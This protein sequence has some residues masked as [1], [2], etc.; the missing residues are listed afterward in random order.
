MKK[1]IVITVGIMML[2]AIV[3]IIGNGHYFKKSNAPIV[4]Q[5][6]AIV[7]SEQLE[8]NKM[9][10]LNGEWFFY[11]NVL[12]S[13]QQLLNGYTNQPILLKVPDKWAGDFQLDEEGPIVGT[14]HLKVKVPVEDQY[15]L[16]FWGIH[17]S[18]RVFINGIEVGGKGNPDTSFAEFRSEND[19]KFMVIGQSE[20]QVLDIL[21]QVASFKEFPNSGIV[22]SVEFG[23]RDTIQHFYDRKRLTDILAIAGY[24][25]FGIIYLISY[26][27]NRKRKEELFFGLFMILMGFHAS[28]I[29]MKIFFQIVP[30]GLTTNQ[31]Q[32]QLGIIPL[33][34]ICMVLF[35]Y[36]MYPQ[37]TSKK[38][39]YTLV[40]FL[41]F[42]FFI[43]GIYN[44]FSSDI[45]EMTK[46]TQVIQ[47]ITYLL[48]IIPGIGYIA[49]IL[50]RIILRNLEGA[51]Y[52]LI[53]FMATCCYSILMIVYILTEIS[54]DYSGLV[55]FL[56]ILVGFSLLLNYR[57]NATFTKQEALTEELQIHNHMKDEFLLKTS[58]ELRTPLNGILNLSKLLM[59]G[60]EGSLKRNQQEQ[61]ILIHNITQRLGEIVEDLLFS[62]N[63]NIS[64]ELRV[65]PRV[66]PVSI[67]ND[68]V[69]EIRSVMSA[70]SYVRLLV[71]VD[72]TLSPMLTD[73]LRFK[74][75][76][77][78]LLHNALQHTELGE[79]IVTAY[80]RQQHM[81][82]EVSDTGKGIPVQDLEH[83]FT[84][85]Y[86]VKN[87]HYQEGLGLGLS[88]AKNIVD[89]LNGT[90]DVKSTLGEGTTFTFTMPL[91]TKS[92]IDSE[93]SPVTTEQM[94][95][96]ILQLELPLIH[97]GNDKKI[98][99]V[100]DEHFNI[101]VLTDAL[102]LKG[103]TVIGVDNGF[104]AID[105]IK[106]NQ[107]DCMLVDLMMEGMSGYELCKQVRKQYD[108]LEL[109]IIV[110]TAIMKHSD[111][112]LT[113]QLGANDYLQKPIAMD[114]LLLRIESLL[115][116]RQSSL[117]AI[118]VEMNNLYSQVTPHFVYN[119]LTTIIGLSYTDM[120]NAREALYCLTTYFRA[121][122]NV[123][124]RNNMILLE[125]EIELVKA[126]LAIE[127][128]RF[129][130]RLTIKYNID[131]SIQLMIPALSLQPLVENAVFHGISKK[132]EGGTIEVSVQ[133]EGQFVQIKIYDNGVGIPAKKLQQ[134][135]NEESP[136]IGF[137]NPLK[138]FKLMKNVSLRLYSKEG[139]GTTILI[140]LPE[141]D[142]A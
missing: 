62:S 2:F 10:K 59:E 135:M 75:V 33:L 98:L 140:L 11:P 109:P 110:L 37:M 97:Q 44:P 24:I 19:D 71:E 102:A 49:L 54:V 87:E 65:S 18:N 130:E 23:T 13:P 5:G 123:H 112:M 36:T 42:I 31:L 114:E 82:I 86:R 53:V 32:F 56:C 43:Y 88:I 67:I 105:Y 137:T 47:Q 63:H 70:N 4:K 38:V 26:G 60:A 116:V 64:G 15:G 41:S 106:T 25:V 17:N 134:L 20:E 52:V 30:I 129:G 40:S 81:V 117:D 103:Y 79:V 72:M 77:Y 74:Q 142:D 58:H 99:V 119:T 138:K 16:F 3:F 61:V 94:P 50:I 22:E 95:S 111:F 78:N 83:I 132:S 93:A 127:K 90:I 80:Q 12:L 107:V 7:T 46:R 131:E 118:E 89:K 85:F 96:A 126:Y 139:K 27:Q 48:L 124:S 9:I 21:I 115:A 136:R 55:L 101:K 113:L 76:L 29:S 125:E 1:N 108:M 100:D 73:E 6:V 8:N 92:Q 34:N 120:E 104:A 35:L 121:K 133:R 91:A 141:G 45:S 57:T 122:L 69:T 39:V 68:V 51:S 28:F 84:A 14:Y 66:V 128:M